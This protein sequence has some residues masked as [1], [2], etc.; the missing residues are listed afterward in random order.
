[1]KS[2]FLF[3]SLISIYIVF[4]VINTLLDLNIDSSDSKRFRTQESIKNI[5]D[6]QKDINISY[7]SINE[8]WGLEKFKP[9]ELN[10]TKD[11]NNTIP[12][13]IDIQLRDTNGFYTIIISQKEF[14]ILGVAQ[15]G[16]KPFVVL[17][18]R[19]ITKRREAIKKYYKN[20]IIYKNTRIQ[21]IDKSHILIVD[22]KTYKKLKVPYFFVD[23]KDFK[24]KEEDNDY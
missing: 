22:S 9:K 11:L 2:K 12:K 7:I 1:M 16:E 23:A 5:S 18:D 17:Y 10:S 24:P 15:K 8:I 14:D 13:N 20:N 19:N 3:L 6:Y 4:V 21:K